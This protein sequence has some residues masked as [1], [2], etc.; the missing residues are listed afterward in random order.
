LVLRGWKMREEVPVEEKGWLG[1]DVELEGRAL[2][3]EVE[4]AGRGG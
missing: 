2:E 4:G 1:G 3:G